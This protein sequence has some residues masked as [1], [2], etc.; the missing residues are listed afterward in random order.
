[1]WHHHLHIKCLTEEQFGLRSALCININW[2]LSSRCRYHK[3]F[4]GT[5]YMNLWQYRKITTTF[6]SFLEFGFLLFDFWGNTTQ[7][8]KDLQQWPPPF[9]YVG[10]QASNAVWDFDFVRHNKRKEK[11]RPFLCNH[12]D[13]AGSLKESF[14]KLFSL[15]KLLSIF[16]VHVP[17]TVFCNLF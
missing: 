14:H 7:S 17:I 8:T 9:V 12:W 13:T 5:K 6:F 16:I 4:S 1:M 2:A 15:F 3:W 11:K 10:G